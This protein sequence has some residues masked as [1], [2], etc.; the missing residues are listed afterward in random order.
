[1]LQGLVDILLRQRRPS[2]HIVFGPPTLLLASGPNENVPPA[3]FLRPKEQAPQL[4][5]RQLAPVQVL[6]VPRILFS[7]ACVDLFLLIAVSFARVFPVQFPPFVFRRS[8]II[9]SILRF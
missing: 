7:F 5:E 3:H 2:F 6:P 4:A 1:M 9:P 8:L